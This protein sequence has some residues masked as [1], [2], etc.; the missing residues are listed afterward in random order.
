ME[1]A[2]AA[3]SNFLSKDG[4]HETTVHET[5]N[6]AITKE[7]VKPEHHEHVQKAVD[8]EVHQHHHHT[9][10]QP[11]THQEVLPEKHAHNIANTEHREIK[12]GNDDHVRQRL[13]AERAQF[14]NV[15]E[16]GDTHH[17]SST[18]P[19]ATGEHI[20]HHVHENI[21]PVIQKETIQPSVVHTTIPVHEVHHNEAKHH[22]ATTLPT[23]TMTDF[24]KQGG[25][26]GGRDE[27]TDRFQGEPRAVGETLA[28]GN[29]NS[30]IGG[31]GAAGTTSLTDKDG[32]TGQS[33]TTRDH[34]LRSNVGTGATGTTGTT[35][36]ER[37]AEG[38]DYDRTG[39]GV[40]GV[41]GNYA[42]TRDTTG[43]TGTTGTTTDST[44]GTTKKASL[45]DKINPM[46]DSN[47]DGQKGFMK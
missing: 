23:V 26:L 39:R 33:G 9:S 32:R 10:V 7:V 18:A 11:I 13:E 34:G 3:V 40:D 36:R 16:V 15:K 35:G 19:V 37:I 30:T 47:G 8:R 46:V 24:Q 31:P 45:M 27:R 14:K 1:K 43:T 41:D 22:T 25:S 42:G 5:V 29:S 2:K 12:H 28:G 6:P 20:H 17:T 4:H 38:G 44:T 21:Q